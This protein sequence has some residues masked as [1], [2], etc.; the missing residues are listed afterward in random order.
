MHAH[1]LS[2][3][4]LVLATV[5]LALAP[6][7]AA[8]K[9]KD[10]A[11]IV[12]RLGASDISTRVLALR[13]MM[14]LAPPAKDAAPIL[15]KMLDD[16]S[17]TVRSELVWAVEELLGESGTPMLEKLYADPE[18]SVRDAAIQAACRMFDKS[19]P[20]D[21][22]RAAFD[23]P[24]AN[25]RIEVLRTLKE[26]HPR[27]PEA[28]AIF[29]RGLKDDSELAQRAAVFGAQAARD[30]KAVDLLYSAALESSPMVGVPAA[31]EAL[32]TIATKEAVD[33]LIA[34]LPKP[35]GE[36]GKPARPED[37]VRAAAARALARVKDTRA[38]PAL[39]KLITDPDVPVRLGAMEALMEM[40]DRDSVPLIA[41][42]L[43]DPEERLR[44]FALRAL[45]VIGDPSAAPAVRKTLHSDKLAIVRAT[46]V[47]TLTDLLGDD[48]IA[49]LKKA[50]ADLD[51]SVR[52]EVAGSL[53]ALGGKAA[54]TLADMVGDE[55]PEVRAMAIVGLGQI[56]GPEQIP[57]LDKAALS[58]DRRN[59]QVRASVAEAL[60]AIG[61]AKGLPTLTRLASDPEP[62]VRQAS[63]DALGRI[64]GGQAQSL[65]AELAKDKVGRVR[66]AAR[67][68][69][70]ALK[71]P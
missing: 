20:R 9:G 54:P 35:K 4:F 47:S 46:A 2:R 8:D 39:R 33:A 57:V 64:G 19:R 5:A 38:L 25:A 48:A 10:L 3:S 32:A 17:E 45:R 1:L 52:L 68:A 59:K 34:L 60:G 14:R 61:S 37:P 16:P 7:G 70:A 26:R 11:P 24:D 13:D 22:C 69:L 36:P 67:R 50:A 49:D 43:Q 40:K 71:N 44:R 66:Q 55:A 21:L 30:P 65:L 41:T 29:R 62:S 28:A 15:Q 58:T 51:A 6:A 27:H 42:Q 31:A 56:G 12:E 53:A 63:A 23:D 18:R